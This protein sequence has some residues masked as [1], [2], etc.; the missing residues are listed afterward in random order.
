MVSRTPRLHARACTALTIAVVG[1][2][3]A[4]Q[5][6]E[7]KVASEDTVVVHTGSLRDGVT[8]PQV[9]DAPHSGT[10]GASASEPNDSSDALAAY[11]KERT[12]ATQIKVYRQSFEEKRSIQIATAESL[13]SKDDYSKQYAL[14]KVLV[15]P[16]FRTLR[17]AQKN[18]TGVNL[19]A[20]PA[21]PNKNRT[22]LTAVVSTWEGT[23]MLG[24]V[25]LRLPDILHR[26]IDNHA[27]RREV[28]NWAVRLCLT[29]PIVS[30]PHR[31]HMS[32]VLQEMGMA[33]VPDP[34]YSNPFSE[35]SKRKRAAEREA[36][37]AAQ[38]RE[39]ERLVRKRG[40]GPLLS[41]YR[42]PQTTV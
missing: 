4:V 6:L 11:P 19:T 3:V 42:R 17:Q 12:E 33:D 37:R 16:I 7:S 26:M 41:R 30:G 15:D 34:T 36:A 14:A 23:A 27:L 29:S 31:K 2:A 28:L 32:L 8:A 5:A 13:A 40:R 1:I 39:I 20:L 35:V 38:E 9:D 24:D 22:I 18:L 10:G 25:I 21:V